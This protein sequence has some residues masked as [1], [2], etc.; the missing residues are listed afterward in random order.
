METRIKKRKLAEIAGGAPVG[1]RPLTKRK[2]M[3]EHGERDLLRL[4]ARPP[5][6]LIIV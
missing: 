1:R 5:K 2:H 6:S 3:A 4:A